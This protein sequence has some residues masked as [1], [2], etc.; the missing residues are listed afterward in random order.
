MPEKRYRSPLREEQADETRRR[1]QQA[2]RQL[3]EEVGFVGATITEIARR[4]GV[5]AATVYSNFESKAGIVRAM[6][7]GLEE[8][9][10]MEW[11]ISRMIA[12]DDPV[13]SLD[14]FVAGNRAVFELGHVILRAAYD[15]M[16]TPEVRALAEAGNANRQH[17]IDVLISR[18]HRQ[19]ALRAGLGP[20]KAAQTM[21]LLT[22]VEQYLLATE[23]L[24]WS[25]NDY[26]R[27]LRRLLRQTLLAPEPN[28]TTD[29]EPREVTSN[30]AAHGPH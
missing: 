20:K 8:D 2:A 17:V 30:H 29:A 10:G 4:A 13:R 9:A 25:E 1:I 27:W 7:D 19:N 18:W 6:L 11:R 5:S 22:S 3:F 26:E 14:L 28:P 23:T 16:G 24:G 15:A 12:E 21:W